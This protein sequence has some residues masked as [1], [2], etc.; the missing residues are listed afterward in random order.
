MSAPG[1]T[2]F[3]APGSRSAPY[4]LE[5]ILLHNT[6]LSEAQL[7]QARTLQSKT[8]GHLLD[9]LVHHPIA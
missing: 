9:I 2:T 1:P 5:K 4:G 3:V 6:P 7:E 8:G